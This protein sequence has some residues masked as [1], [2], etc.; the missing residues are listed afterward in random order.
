MVGGGE[1]KKK[2]K[3]E[4]LNFEFLGLDHSKTKLT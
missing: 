3:Q 1:E 4:Q 2:E